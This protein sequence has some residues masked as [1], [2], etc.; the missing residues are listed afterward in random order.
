MRNAPVTNE[1]SGPKHLLNHG[2]Q[3]LRSRLVQI[4]LRSFFGFHTIKCENR[5]WYKG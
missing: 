5:P 1:I 3:P 2:S 4:L